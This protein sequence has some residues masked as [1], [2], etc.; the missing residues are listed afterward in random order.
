MQKK[1]FIAILPP[2]KIFEEIEK[3]KQEL[4]FRYKLKGALRSPA[5]IT[6][7]RPFEWKA[8]KESELIE[9]LA[10]FSFKRQFLIELKNF[11]C[12]SPRVIYVDVAK[13]QHLSDLHL[14]LKGHCRRNLHLHNEDEDMRGFVPHITVASRDL[15]KQLFYRLWDYEFR[16]RQFYAEFDYSGFTLLRLESKWE[17]IRDF[18]I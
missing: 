1:Y 10:S 16:S 7:F 5:H 17:A 15:K 9:T 13:N 2:G 14:A 8:E 3:V 11:N 6:L 12:F 18:G 4:H